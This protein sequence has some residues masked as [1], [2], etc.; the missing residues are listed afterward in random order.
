LAAKGGLFVLVF[1]RAAAAT[2][3]V[4]VTSGPLAGGSYTV[5]LT[6][7]AAA[8]S[9]VFQQYPEFTGSYSYSVTSTN[10]ASLQLNFTEPP[11]ARG[12][13][14]LMNLDFATNYRGSFSGWELIQGTRHEN[15]GGDFQTGTESF[16]DSCCGV[17]GT[18]PCCGGGSGCCVGVEEDLRPYAFQFGEAQRM[19]GKI[20]ILYRVAGQIF[21]LLNSEAERTNMLAELTGPGKL[22]D[23]YSPEFGS[24]ASFIL[25]AASA[26]VPA[27]LA[28]P[29]SLQALIEQARQIHGVR[30][31]SPVF[32]DLQENLRFMPADD[33]V[34][35]LVPGA[36]PESV[37][38]PDSAVSQ[39]SGTGEIIV[40]LRGVP[41]K[42][43]IREINLLTLDPRVRWAEPNYF[44]EA[45]GLS[46]KSS[47][48]MDTSAAL[49]RAEEDCLP[50]PV[51]LS[52]S[53]EAATQN[54]TVTIH[55]IRDRIVTIQRSTPDGWLEATNL[56][57]GEERSAELPIGTLG[58]SAIFRA[59][60]Y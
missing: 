21:I 38:P 27:Q 36:D 46:T 53:F 13:I 52:S 8:G 32:L 28:C 39:E 55:G 12:D 34:V 31:A 56:T 40:H 43:M 14:D 58:S 59:L 4:S 60:A 3:Q 42:E 15:F 2:L 35:S 33:Y 1:A 11:S 10:H 6:G 24:G 29:A 48:T 41:W 9:F 25:R 54:L 16:W 17:E 23:G 45:R 22:L 50:E 49:A 7:G 47:G 18:I 57:G 19:P 51:R 26:E 44:A 20:R 30:C 37:L 5:V